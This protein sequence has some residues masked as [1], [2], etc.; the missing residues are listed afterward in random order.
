MIVSRNLRLRHVLHSTWPSLLYFTGLSIAVYFLH[1]EFD[2]RTLSLPFNAVAT[3]ST[4]LAIYLGFKANQAYDRWWEGR[5]IWGLLVN[6]SRAF[7]REILTFAQPTEAAELNAL[8]SWQQ[9]MLRRHI[10]FV[11]GLRVFLRKPNGFVDR[12]E[13][14]LKPENSYEDMADFLDP[15]E[16][17]AVTSM[18]NPPNHILT[19]Q[20]EELVAAK[21]NGWLSDYRFVQLS[22]TLTEFNNHQGMAERI[23]NT[24]LPRPYSFY[25]RVFVYLHGTLVPFA[26][27]EDLTWL[28]I[29]LSLTINFVFLTLDLVGHYTEDPFENRIADVPLTAIALTIEENIKEMAQI[30]LPAHPLP[31]KPPPVEGVVF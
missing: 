26:F 30:K 25:S 16:Y 6:Y 17:E 20:G 4:A 10:A 27:I 29:P 12:R 3:L 28:N 7:S 23:K 1:H 5:K 15:A 14:L 18:K 8:R 24:P 31:Q 22:Q 11:H 13:E 2:L 21:H 19:L 9:H